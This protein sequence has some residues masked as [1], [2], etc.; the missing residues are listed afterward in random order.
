M[1]E[2]LQLLELSG[3][4][5]LTSEQQR[6]RAQLQRALEP[7]PPWSPATLAAFERSTLPSDVQSFLT[8]L[9]PHP[10]RRL[11]VLR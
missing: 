3:R 11:P 2:L 6:R 8:S 5:P 7:S 1:H 10:Q 4:L 9:R